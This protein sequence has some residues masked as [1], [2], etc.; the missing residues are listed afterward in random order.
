MAHVDERNFRLAKEGKTGTTPTPE[1]EVR[2]K[3]F[4]KLEKAG[5]FRRKQ[6]PKGEYIQLKK[7]GGDLYSGVN[8]LRSFR[9]HSTCK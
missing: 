4:D 1:Q 2:A 5:V 8:S 9:N 3:H 7:R 6:L